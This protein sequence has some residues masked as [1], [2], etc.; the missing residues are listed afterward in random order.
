M[1]YD[2]ADDNDFT[3]LLLLGCQEQSEEGSGEEVRRKVQ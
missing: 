1:D 2:G 3:A